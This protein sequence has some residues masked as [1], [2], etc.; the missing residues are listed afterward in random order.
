MRSSSSILMVSAGLAALMLSGCGGHKAAPAPEKSHRVLSATTAVVGQVQMQQPFKLTGLQ[1]SRE[2]AAVSSELS[3][4]RI[5]KVFVEAGATVTAGQP[6]AQMDDSLLKNLVVQQ[7]A[8]VAQQQVAYD[9][10]QAEA[11][12]VANLDKE[13][14]LSSEIVTERTLAAESAKASLAQAKAALDDYNVRL[15]LMTIRAPVGG[16]VLTRTAR[17]GDVASVGTTLFTIARDSLVELEANVPEAQLAVMQA[18]TPA[19]VTLPDGTRLDG[20][21]RLVSPRVDSNSKLGTVRIALP[22]DNHLRPGGYGEAT[23]QGRARDVL[24]VPTS[25]LAYDADGASLFV[26]GSD[27]IA[28]RRVVKTGTVAD[29]V[30]EILSGVEPGARIVAKGAA[31]LLDGDKIRAAA[32]GTEH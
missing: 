7:Q 5:S 15:S 28:H 9:K 20:Q 27:S 29:G 2:E 30:T 31:L 13:G 18:G 6:L 10:A 16:I 1:V 32:A 19:Q 25:A 12:R 23:V 3:G 26:V 21:V 24:A 22:V 11:S 4:Y 17:P 14:A 8:I